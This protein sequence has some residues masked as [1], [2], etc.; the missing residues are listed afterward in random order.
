MRKTQPLTENQW[1]DVLGDMLE[2]Q[3]KVFNR[4][5]PQMCYEILVGSLLSSARKENIAWAGLML[6]LNNRPAE[7]AS[8]SGKILV[9]T[10]RDHYENPNDYIPFERSKK[11]ILQAAEEYIN[12]S[13]NLSDPSLEL[14]NYCLGLVTIEDEQIQ[15]EKVK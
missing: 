15:E 11:F 6:Q 4:I 1:K 8:V 9:E 13:E 3:K 12:S 14:A 2:L 7:G 10:H 5:T